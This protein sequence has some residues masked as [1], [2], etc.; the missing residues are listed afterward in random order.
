MTETVILFFLMGEEAFLNL[1]KTQ[2]LNIDIGT[3]VYLT[4]E[5]C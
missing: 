2:T 3:K 1:K 4:I 5:G